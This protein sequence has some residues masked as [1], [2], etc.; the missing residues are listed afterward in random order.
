[1]R[2]TIITAIIFFTSFT[3][4][5]QA[6]T[7]V[8]NFKG[9][10]FEISL[11]NNA[12]KIL[13][14]GTVK[15]YQDKS[16]YV[17][18]EATHFGVYDFLLPLGHRYILEFSGENMVSKKIEIDARRCPEEIEKTSVDFDVV[19]FA[20]ASDFQFNSLNAPIAKYTWDPRIGVLLNDD[21]YSFDQTKA[22]KKEVR[23][24]KKAIALAEK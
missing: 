1:M 15:V 4:Y 11:K 6:P 16:L 8:L 9:R 13:K 24:A 22:L 19:L 21:D 23:K 10:L 2:A 20:H 18:L 12:E 17:F 3:G 14:T 5:S 7:H